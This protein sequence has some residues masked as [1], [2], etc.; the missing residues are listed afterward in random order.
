[1]SL[2]H[3]F[4]AAF[5]AAVAMLSGKHVTMWLAGHPVTVPVSVLA[6]SGVLAVV[7][8]LCFLIARRVRR[9]GFG[10]RPKGIAW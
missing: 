4:L 10:I 5:L 2:T 9:D 1:M 6:L 8:G 7:V 3:R